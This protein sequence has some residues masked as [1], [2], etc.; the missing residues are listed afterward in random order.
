M[1]REVLDGILTDKHRAIGLYLEDTGTFLLLCKEG[2]ELPVAV[3][4]HYA[5]VTAILHAAD[6]ELSWALSGISFERGK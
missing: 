4:S 5:S 3:L 1:L 2:R 6:Q